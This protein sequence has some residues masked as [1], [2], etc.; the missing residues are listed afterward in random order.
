MVPTAARLH[1]V[2]YEINESIKV[3]SEEEVKI[4]KRYIRG[5]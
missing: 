5:T 2:I 3:R 4:Y 1:L